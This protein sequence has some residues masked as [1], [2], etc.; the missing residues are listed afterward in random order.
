M[1]FQTLLML[2]FSL[3]TLISALPNVHEVEHHAL[4]A[5]AKKK[6]KPHPHPKPLPP[7]NRPKPKQQ[8][9]EPKEVKCDPISKYSTSVSDTPF[10]P[11]IS[12]V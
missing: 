8:P 7:K 11:S 4:E 3:F 2:A 5:R 9:H 1:R 6:T 12:P 10:N